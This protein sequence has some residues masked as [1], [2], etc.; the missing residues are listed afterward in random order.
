MRTARIDRS[1]WISLAQPIWHNPDPRTMG[2]SL[3][4]PQRSCTY[5]I[6][7]LHG[8]ARHVASRRFGCLAASSVV[9]IISQSLC[10][11]LTAL[12]VQERFRGPRLSPLEWISTAFPLLHNAQLEGFAR[13]CT[14]VAYVVRGGYAHEPQVFAGSQL[15]QAN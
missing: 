6:T 5:T 15:R 14:K 9:T 13:A 8:L 2:D 4:Y 11:Y 7:R 1:W 10:L 12:Y 3:G